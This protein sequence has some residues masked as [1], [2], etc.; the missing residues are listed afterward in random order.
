MQY[1]FP[2]NQ[3]I[4]LLNIKKIEIINFINGKDVN[5]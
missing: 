1:K 3:I 5:A 4:I 2:Y